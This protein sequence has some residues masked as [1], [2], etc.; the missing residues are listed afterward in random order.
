MAQQVENL[1]DR[2]VPELMRELA[3]ETGTLVRQELALARAEVTQSARRTGV[4]IGELGGAALIGL[5]ALGCLTV[6]A[7][8]A[9]AL[10]MPVWLAALI[11]GVLYGGAAAILGLRGRTEIAAAMP[12][13]PEQTIETVKEDVEWAKTRMSSERP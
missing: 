9:L 8:A 7:I 1:H 11:V 5:F 4:G 2:S 13:K 10:A 12:P 3:Q 6:C